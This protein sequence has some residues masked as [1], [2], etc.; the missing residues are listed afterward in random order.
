[1]LLH[2]WLSPVYVQ[3]NYAREHAAVIAMLASRR[4]VTTAIGGGQFG[5]LWRATAH[6]LRVL[7]G[8]E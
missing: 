4:M 3:A 7:E 8:S 6:G 1:M 2:I 5:R